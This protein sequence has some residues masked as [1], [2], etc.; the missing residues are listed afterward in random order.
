MH[1]IFV[2][3]SP[4]VFANNS[5]SSVLDTRKSTEALFTQC[6]RLCNIKRSKVD[7][8]GLLDQNWISS[9]VQQAYVLS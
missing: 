9:R 5:L 8:N 7:V 1:H 2:E 3:V 6:A 4:D